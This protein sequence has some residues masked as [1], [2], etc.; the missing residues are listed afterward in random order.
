M[1]NYIGNY[2]DSI[3]VETR[4]KLFHC[5]ITTTEISRYV[6]HFKLPLS[7]PFEV[8]DLHML[9]NLVIFFILHLYGNMSRD[10][11]WCQTIVTIGLIN[12][13]WNKLMTEEGI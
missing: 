10:C 7:K 8:F 2:V 11:H 12:E 13:F 4:K 9:S 1:F 5:F 6:R 3:G